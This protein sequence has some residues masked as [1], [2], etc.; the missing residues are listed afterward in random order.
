MYDEIEICPLNVYHVHL[1]KTENISDFG[2]L[3]GIFLFILL[4]VYFLS[5]GLF[6]LWE[7]AG[8]SLIA[9]SLSLQRTQGIMTKSQAGCFTL[10]SAFLM[11]GK[12]PLS[13]SAALAK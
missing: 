13:T 12:G 3:L 1:K 4:I 9:Q 8:P 11:F 5:S 10:T 7:Q 2:K 6:C